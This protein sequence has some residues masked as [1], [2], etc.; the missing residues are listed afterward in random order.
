MMLNFSY[1]PF[2]KFFWKFLAKNYYNSITSKY[3]LILTGLTVLSFYN[4][5]LKK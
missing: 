5:R 3:I 4:A 2:L 1:S